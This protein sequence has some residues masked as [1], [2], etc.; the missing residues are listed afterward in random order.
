MTENRRQEQ[1]F[2]Q[3]DAAMFY[4]QTDVAAVIEGIL[5]EHEAVYIPEMA[6]PLVL[7]RPIV[8]KSGRHLKVHERTVF[9]V[10]EGCGGCMV[11]NEHIFNGCGGQA[12]ETGYD[13]GITVEGGVWQG[14][15]RAESVNDKSP[16]MHELSR[17]ILGVL[18]FSHAE[19]IVIRNVT[20]RSG[21]Q[22]GVLLAD[23]HDFRVENIFFDHHR[24]DGVHVNGPACR[25]LIEGV[26]GRC[27]DD[28]VALNAWDWDSSSISF[29]PIRDIVV[30]H[31]C[32]DHNELRML[33]GRKTYPNGEKVEC[34]IER[35]L[36]ED[37][38]GV[39]NFKL[40]QQPNCHNATRKDKD[41]SEIAGLLRDV[42]F[43]NIRLA[44]LEGEGFSEVRLDALFEM[45]ADCQDILFEDI[46]LGFDEEAFRAKG[47][48]LAIIGPK[49]STWTRGSKD[50]AT[51]SELFD[52]DLIC[53]AE[54]ITFKNVCFADHVCKD[55]EVLICEQHLTVNPDYPNTLPQGGTG[56]GIA[57]D[58]VIL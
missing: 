17:I 18:F 31:V 52:P 48:R 2:F 53:T 11:R 20:I 19:Q 3:A 4:G 42:Q 10:R 41:F 57:K 21:E 32:C 13:T 58:I 5:A 50:P 43:K 55:R 56:Y 44:A 35:C 39:Y 12:P 26:T 9:T 23:C 1:V 24:K 34:P 51:W 7:D 28:I 45:G 29:G 46:S 15:A 14:G 30:R 16:V 47:M 8:L 37:V 49:S 22:Y 27:D 33:P 38:E 36:V 6:A 54:R 25:G 40:Y